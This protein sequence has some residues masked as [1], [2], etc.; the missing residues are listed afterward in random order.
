V[1]RPDDARAPV[2]PRGAGC[3]AGA[4]ILAALATSAYLPWL[5]DDKAAEATLLSAVNDESTLAE[6]AKRAD[7]AMQLNPLSIDRSRADRDR[8]EARPPEEVGDLI[9]EAVDRQPENPDVWLQGL[10][11]QHFIDDAPGADR[12][13]PADC[14]SSTRTRTG[15]RS[16]RWRATSLPSRRA[17]PARRS[18]HSCCRA[19]APPDRAARAGRAPADRPAADRRR[20]AGRRRRRPLAKRRQ[21][22]L[23]PVPER[24]LGSQPS[25]PHARAGSIAMCCTSPRRGGAN[26]ARSPSLPRSRAAPRRAEDDVW[27]AEPDVERR[28]SRASPA[29][30]RFARTTSPTYT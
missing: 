5:A 20:R 10:R 29:A 9:E 8:P 24:D 17:R 15:S 14:S 27:H 30:A 4:L 21:S 16:T 2:G 13:R 1:P 11:V 18:S 3:C 25:S 22:P 23:Q 12:E 7:E 26:S 28:R 19:T 6:A